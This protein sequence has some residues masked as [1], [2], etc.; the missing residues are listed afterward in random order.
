MSTF[1]ITALILGGVSSLVLL[2]VS[3]MSAIA[4]D[5]NAYNDFVYTPSSKDNLTVMTSINEGEKFIF[6]KFDARS[7]DIPV[8]TLP[9]D[10]I[11]SLDGDKMQLGEIYE[12][13]GFTSTKEAINQTF[14]FEV[15]NLWKINS[16][17]FKEVFKIFGDI[18][19]DFPM[20]IMT[21]KKT[22]MKGKQHINAKFIENILSTNKDNEQ[23][24]E[25]CT[26][27]S[28]IY[29]KLINEKINMI[30]DN[31][32]EETVMSFL[33]VGKN[34]ISYYDFEA[35]RNAIIFVAKMKETPSVF[36]ETKG[37]YFDN[38]Y[39]ISE[40][41]KEIIIKLFDKKLSTQTKEDPK[42]D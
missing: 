7:G 11:V 10:T 23:N 32:I 5:K 3:P 20:D 19:V 13:R 6:V 28:I 31:S 27:I 35:R 39:I 29:S 41:T 9:K 24:E 37:K 14:G 38:D 22:I 12:K 36:I 2:F 42:K 16:E 25:I 34:D 21:D 8:V 17:D 1:L 40:S 18:Y 4:G 15:N 30:L 26:A 33:D